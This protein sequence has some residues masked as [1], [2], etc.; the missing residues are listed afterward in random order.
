MHKIHIGY[1]KDPIYNL[2]VNDYYAFINLEG[3]KFYGTFRG[4]SG[5]FKYGKPTSETFLKIEDV[6]GDYKTKKLLILISRLTE[7]EHNPSIKKKSPHSRSP[8]PNRISP[9]GRLIP[10][11]DKKRGSRIGITGMLTRDI[12]DDVRIAHERLIESKVKDKISTPKEEVE[13]ETMSNHE[14]KI[15]INEL[16]V[17]ERYTFYYKKQYHDGAIIRGTFLEYL[18][19]E[20]VEKSSIKI[21]M[22]SENGK[23]KSGMLATPSSFI[24]KVTQNNIGPRNTATLINSFLGG[25]RRERK[26]NKLNKTG[27]RTTR[28]SR[29]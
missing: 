7:M 14:I 17:G 5:E 19:S 23:K 9:T 8:S 11:L 12:P 4:Y 24:K 15:D 1:E 22:F 6:T 28:K 26:T 27:K 2:I 13:K 25:R 20:E 29:K 10:A 3:L 16:V 21:G 18:S